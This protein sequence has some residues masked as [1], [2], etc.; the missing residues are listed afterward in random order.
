MKTD[1]LSVFVLIRHHPKRVNTLSF[2]ARESCRSHGDQNANL[3]P[4]IV[5]RQN[6]P[7]FS[8]PSHLRYCKYAALASWLCLWVFYYKRPSSFSSTGCSAVCSVGASTKCQLQLCAAWRNR[9][10]RGS[11]IRS[12]CRRKTVTIT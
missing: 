2:M 12:C 6:R 7:S 10:T 5:H 1:Q 11:N 4:P 8:S 9:R 3:I